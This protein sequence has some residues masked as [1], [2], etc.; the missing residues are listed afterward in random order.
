M[1]LDKTNSAFPDKFIISTEACFTKQLWEKNVVHLGSWSRGEQYLEN[2]IDVSF[3][4]MY[5]PT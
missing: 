3:S 4:Y 2:I 5:I 1:L